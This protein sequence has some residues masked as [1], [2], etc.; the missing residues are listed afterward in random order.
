MP[1]WTARWNRGVNNRLFSRI[2][3]FVPP[4]ALVIHRGRRSGAEYRTPVLGFRWGD[5]ILVALPYGEGSDWVR[6]LLAAGEGVVL[7]AGRRFPVSQIVVVDRRSR[8]VA[9]LP[10]VLRLAARTPVVLVARINATRNQVNRIGI[11]K[12]MGEADRCCTC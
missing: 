3:P 4:Y 1:A 8:T 2:A 7:H 11:L 12:G 9:D 6:N 5:A 10:R